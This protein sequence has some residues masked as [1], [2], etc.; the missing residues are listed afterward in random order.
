MTALCISRADTAEVSLL[1]IPCFPPLKKRPIHS[2]S[3]VTVG[4]APQKVLPL[5]KSYR[6]EEKPRTNHL[7]KDR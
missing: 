1:P 6:I 7:F 3:T 2:S 5:H 4:I